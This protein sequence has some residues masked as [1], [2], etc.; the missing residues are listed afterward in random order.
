M[1]PYNFTTSLEEV[2]GPKNTFDE[3]MR[4]SRRGAAQVLVEKGHNATALIS[5]NSV[6]IWPQV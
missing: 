3:Y 1:R 4:C 6:L 5:G 2:H